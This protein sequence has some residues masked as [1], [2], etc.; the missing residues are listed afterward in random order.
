MS[1]NKSTPSI[2]LKC[3]VYFCKNWLVSIKKSYLLKYLVVIQTVTSIKIFL[4]Q[5]IRDFSSDIHKDVFLLDITVVFEIQAW[6]ALFNLVQNTFH[7]SSVLKFL[8]KASQLISAIY[9][10]ITYMTS[11]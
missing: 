5:S 2:I 10:Q 4:L 7:G 8:N 1:I 11:S 6:I 3:L 9:L